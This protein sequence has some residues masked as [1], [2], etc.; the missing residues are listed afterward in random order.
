MAIQGMLDFDYS[1]K[2]ARA[3]VAAMIYP[4]SGH[5][6][7]KFYWGTCETLL[8]VYTSEEAVKKRPYVNVVVNFASSSVYSSTMKRLGYESIKAIAS[9]TEGVPEHQAREIL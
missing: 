5:H 9:I 1:C 8:P 3:P 2:R 7:Q 6:V 4:Y